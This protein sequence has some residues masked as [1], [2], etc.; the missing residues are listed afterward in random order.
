MK[1]KK[2]IPLPNSFITGMGGKSPEWVSLE[3]GL[4]YERFEAWSV[5]D[6]AIIFPVVTDLHSIFNDENTAEPGLRN[7]MNH[8]RY[9]HGIA[10]KFNCDFIADLGDIGLELPETSSREAAKRLVEQYAGIQAESQLPTLQCLGNHDHN[11]G[12]ISNAEF[13]DA[14]NKKCAKRGHKIVFGENSS[15]GYYDVPNK[16][17]RVF[18][19]NT[20]DNTYYGFSEEQLRFLAENISLNSTWTVVILTHFCIDPIGHWLNDEPLSDTLFD[21][22]SMFAFLE[23]IKGNKN[24]AGVFAGDSHYDHFIKRDDINFFITQGYGGVDLK[25]MPA[26]AQFNFFDTM[27]NMLVDLVVIEPVKR[28]IKLLRLGAGGE[29]CD[30]HSNF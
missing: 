22:T 25:K 30:R 21:R 16:R 3:M 24:L 26:G 27:K 1:I 5:S 13:G 4:T 18:F 17:C 14:F 23:I 28:E 29:S 9:V 10:E 20:S 11:G 6:D 12:S 19:L 2:Y 7:S 15:Y 8:I